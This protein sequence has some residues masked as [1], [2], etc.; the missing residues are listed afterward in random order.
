[1]RFMRSVVTLAAW[2]VVF[3]ILP[4][5]SHAQVGNPFD[6]LKCYKIKDPTKAKYLADLVPLQ[7][8]PFQVEPDCAV[9]FPAKLFCIPVQKTNVEPP[10]PGAVN[11]VQAQDYLVYQIKCTK[12]PSMTLPV[13][14]QFASRTVTVGNHMFLMVPAFKQS[15][16][17]HNG[18][19]PGTPPVCGGDCTDPFAKCELIPGTT[20]CECRHECSINAAGVCGGTCPQTGQQCQIGPL[21]DGTLGCVC[22]PPF[23]ECHLLN[24]ANKTC[25]GDCT[26]PAAQCRYTTKGK[27][28]CVKPC[29][30]I[31]IRQCGGLCPTASQTCQMKPDDSG[32]ECVGAQPQPCGFLPGSEQ[33]GGICPNNLVCLHV[34]PVPGG[35]CAC[36]IPNQN[37]N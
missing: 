9:K 34:G 10:A 7:Q 31:G 32:C 5:P 18:A 29:G 19:A 17:C 33:C 3:A 20:T 12:L 27:C 25:G 4:V 22:D 28:E 37:P 6:H 15:N 13:T 11:G 36:G 30:S 23:D 8:P 26:D 1:M 2:L 14:D 16:L 35:G 21:A 24:A